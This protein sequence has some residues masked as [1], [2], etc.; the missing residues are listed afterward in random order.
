MNLRAPTVVRLKR[1]LAHWSSRVTVR[2]AY[3][4][5]AEGIA[6]PSRLSLLTVRAIPTEVKPKR[7]ALSSVA[8]LSPGYPPSRTGAA[9]LARGTT[10]VEH[11]RFPNETR[12]GDLG[13]GKLSFTEPPP[14]RA[15]ADSPAS[16][17]AAVAG[18]TAHGRHG[19]YV[20]IVWTILWTTTGVVEVSSSYAK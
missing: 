6:M 16:G 14:R 10:I 3:T 9:P 2:V 7:R 12:L 4:E 17:K 8:G 13:C 18:E 1:T 19:R 5:V 20:H 15:E 11:S